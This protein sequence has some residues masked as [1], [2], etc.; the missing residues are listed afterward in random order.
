MAPNPCGTGW[1]SWY[2]AAAY[3]AEHFALYKA[4]FEAEMEVCKHTSP[5]SLESLHQMT[6]N[7][8][9]S[10]LL[11]LQLHILTEKSKIILQF[12]NLFES[13]RPVAMKAFDF[14]EDLQI[15]FVANKVLK[16]EV[17]SFFE[18][19]GDL[20]FSKKKETLAI[21]EQAYQLAEEKL[22]K[23]MNAA[24]PAIH[25]L[26]ECRIFNPSISIKHQGLGVSVL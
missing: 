3:H 9:L 22:S 7:T 17:C 25:F 5:N 2:R 19:F 14:L 24:Q 18:P 6:Q 21:F 12:S 1:N 13:N 4:F 20:P 23:Y 15:C 16:L 8:M 11:Q 26:R 10:K